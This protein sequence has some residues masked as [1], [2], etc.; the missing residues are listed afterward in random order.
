MQS[1]IEPLRELNRQHAVVLV[2]SH[3]N[4]YAVAQH[5]VALLLSLSNRL[6]LHHNWMAAGR[7]R[8]GDAE[9]AS[10]PL[11]GK[12]V[13]LLGYGRIGRQ[14]HRLLAGFEME[15]GALK[16][17]WEGVYPAAPG[18][19]TRYE[20]A[21]LAGLFEWSNAVIVALPS[22]PETKGLIGSKELARLG[23]RGLLI[24]VARGNIVDEEALYKALRNGVIGGAGIDVWYDYRPEPDAAGRV[25]PYRFPFHELPNVVLSPHRAASPLYVRERWAD[26]IDN[27]RR[28]AEG[29]EPV[30]VVDLEAGY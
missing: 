16:R 26:V 19:V 1:L 29:R 15:F 5:A 10:M 23:E 14:A 30:N 6:V 18:L 13:G 9:A 3:S 8:T 17:G 21:G 20:P 4:A 7:W 25:Y 22:T 2:N 24:N 12:C 11:K 27:L 28:Y